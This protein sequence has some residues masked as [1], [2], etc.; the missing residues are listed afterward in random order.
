MEGAVKR[1]VDFYGRAI[2]L[3]FLAPVFIVDLL[4]KVWVITQFL[5]GNSELN[6]D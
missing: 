2:S 4:L 3:G 5:W 1:P 6:L